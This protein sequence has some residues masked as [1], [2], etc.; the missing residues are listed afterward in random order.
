MFSIA[1]LTKRSRVACDF[2]ALLTR[3]ALVALCLLVWLLCYDNQ[4]YSRLVK[5]AS[6]AYALGFAHSVSFLPLVC[7]QGPFSSRYLQFFLP[8]HKRRRHFR[9][10][11]SCGRSSSPRAE[12]R[13]TCRVL[14][15]GVVGV[16]QMIG[17]C[18]YR[19]PLLI[20]FAYM[21]KIWRFI[22]NVFDIRDGPRFR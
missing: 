2:V 19:I 1:R 5:S 4:T 15:L 14:R 10:P 12:I 6:N 9:N 17:V 22:S 20:I 21:V 11:L 3:I 18:L 7:L 16:R 8:L 13:S